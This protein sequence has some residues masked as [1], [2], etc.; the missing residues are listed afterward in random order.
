MFVCLLESQTC[1][2]TGRNK[3]REGDKGK[4]G[5]EDRDGKNIFHLVFHSPDDPNCQ[6]LARLRPEIRGFIHTP[7]VGGGAQELRLYAAF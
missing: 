7:Q 5:E 1:R 6:D 2:K 4:V 3:E